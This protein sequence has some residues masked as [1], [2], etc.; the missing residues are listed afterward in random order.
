MSTLQVPSLRDALA[1]VP[2]FRQAQGRRYELLPVLLLSC[3][4]VMCGARSQA[5]IAEWGTNYGIR[6]LTRLGIQRR[7]GPSQPTLHRIFKALDGVCLEHCVTRW[8]EQVLT[9]C[10]GTDAA[11]EALSIDGKSLRGSAQQGAAESHLLSAISQRLG[12]VVAQLAVS[13]KSHEA[14]SVEALLA[15]LVLEGRVVTLDA[16]HTHAWVAQTILDGGGDYLLPVKDNQ[17]LLR[18]DIALVFAHA[19]RLADTITEARSTDQHGGR[20]ETRRLRA[21]TALQGYVDWPGHQQ[22]LE[23]RRTVTEKRTGQ[24]RCEVVHAITSLEPE[25][26]TTRQLLEMWRSHWHIENRL[27]WV[28]DVTFDEDR[29]QV[30]AGHAP[31]VMAALRNVAISLLRLC[32]AENIAA[33][34]RRY[35]AR[36]SLALAAVGIRLRE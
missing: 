20:I 16:L 33:A 3:V 7:R 28:R 10:A 36:P 29:S 35:A 27:H 2:D 17:P 8:A 21:S 1:D 13:D 22:V 12:L 4:A 11:L 18:Q 19:D 14:A 9:A 34:C 6:W 5:A 30:R 32:G 15:A 24:T 23:L 25:R 31:Q 26:A